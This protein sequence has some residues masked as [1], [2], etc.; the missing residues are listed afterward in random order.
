MR[1]TPLVDATALDGEAGQQQRLSSQAV[2]LFSLRSGRVVPPQQVEQP[3]HTK[4]T[5]PPPPNVRAHAP[6][7]PPSAMRSPGLRYANGS[8][9][10][11]GRRSP[12]RAPRTLGSAVAARH[13]WSASRQPSPCLPGGA[14]RL[15]GGQPLAPAH[16]ARTL[17]AHALSPP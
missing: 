4:D 17:A 14:P 11:T 6:G 3:V 5:A 16:D 8:P 12:N 9:R 10:T 7:A 2:D 13:P 1:D 15:R